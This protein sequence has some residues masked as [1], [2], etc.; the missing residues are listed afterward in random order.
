MD[1]KTVIQLAKQGQ[2]KN[3]ALIS[4][5][6]KNRHI[7]GGDVTLCQDERQR[8]HTQWHDGELILC[9]D[10]FL[11]ACRDINAGHDLAGVFQVLRIFG[12]GFIKC[13]DG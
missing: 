1:V 9:V 5:Q 11:A 6:Q 4:P 10:E 7:W 3:P 2:L 12:G 13:A 8:E